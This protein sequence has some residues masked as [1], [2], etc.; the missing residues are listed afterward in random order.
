VGTLLTE[1]NE[2]LE[3][4][5][6]DGFKAYKIKVAARKGAVLRDLQIVV[7]AANSA[8]FEQEYV[9]FDLMLRR[10]APKARF[11]D[12]P[13]RQWIRKSTCAEDSA[14]TTSDGIPDIRAFVDANP[15][16]FP[17]LALPMIGQ[18]RPQAPKDEDG[19]FKQEQVKVT[20]DGQE[21]DALRITLTHGPRCYLK[22]PIAF[23]ATD[24]NTMTFFAKIQVPAGLSPLIGDRK[25]ELWGTDAAALNSPFDTFGVGLY[26][27]S[28]DFEDWGRYGV[29][30][31]MLTQNLEL[32]AHEPKD[33]EYV[34]APE[35]T[36]VFAYDI[37]N[38]DPSGNKSAFYPKLTHWTFYYDNKKIPEGEQVVITIAAPKVTRGLM[39]AGG[40]IPAYKKF[41]AE[42]EQWG[43]INTKS[44]KAALDAPV[45]SRLNKPI[46][47][48]TNHK[49]QGAIYVDLS[50]I[51]P[52]YDVVV[53][54][55]VKEMADLL[56]QKY[57]TSTPIS[58]LE[59]PPPKGV[60]NAVIIGGGA[61]QA[62]DRK[63]YDADIKALDGTPGCAIR[64]NG[65]NVYIYAAPFNYAGPARGLANGIYTFLEN[66]TGVI[67]ANAEQDDKEG[68]GAV[69]DLSPSGNFDI[70][71][72]QDYR[73]IPPLNV[74]G[75]SGVPR[76]HN[77]RNRAARTS[78][79][80]NW[81]Y[82]GL[83]A[84]STNHWWGYGTG[85]NGQKGEPND[86]WGVG[87][88]GKLMLP[89]TYTGHP[90]LVRVL[91]NAKEAYVSASGFSPTSGDYNGQFPPGEA[92]AWNSYDVNGLWVEDTR[93]VCQCSECA[94]PIRLADG[95]RIMRD[96]PEFLSTQFFSNGCAM[97]NAV[98]VYASR[99]ARVE[100]I[101]YFWMTPIP[102]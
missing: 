85:S 4:T 31:A 38:S 73:N 13:Q 41:L 44:G 29:M 22:F 57:T 79:W 49:P 71:W 8:D 65:T 96:E 40:D 32:D 76:W 98:N 93:K 15:Q 34:Q 89:G 9:I 62:I 100:S 60:A 64:S 6:K 101:A 83:R 50:G 99:D 7:D 14:L 46:P 33:G 92:F 10:N 37:I 82:A 91:E 39:Y 20:L 26:S 1:K 47:F 17:S 80:G 69:F 90:C 61:F 58:V 48:I 87:K 23:D 74:W 66:N 3:T 35:E 84:R 52:V 78:V 16:D 12:L 72:G 97:I 36:R 27:A 51:K 81:T 54:R 63:S 28:H 59:T 30:Q 55:A 42:R 67:F 75:I 21:V 68:A 86:T 95:S 19:G 45:T 70:V 18:L 2:D 25:P 94:M 102:R 56:N 5:W 88:D 77:D 24:Y 43:L 11:T 53:R